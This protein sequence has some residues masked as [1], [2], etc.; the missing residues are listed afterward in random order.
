MRTYVFGALLLRRQ[1]RSYREDDAFIA[2]SFH[3][4]GLLPAFETPKGSF[5]IDGADA[6]E[7]W[8]RQQ[9]GSEAE[10]DRIWFAVELHDNYRALPLHQ[11]PEAMLVYLGAGADVDGPAPGDLEPKQIGEVVAA[12][13]RLDFKLRFTELLVAHCERKPDS[14]DGTWLEGLCRAHGAR[15]PPSDA[16]EREIADAPFAE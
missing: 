16:V 5:E 8:A 14:Q 15:L 12:F 9:G 4:L 3:D 10:A 1:L 13:P 11:G 6:A 7:G 2:A